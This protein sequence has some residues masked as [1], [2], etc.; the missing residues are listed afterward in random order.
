MVRILTNQGTMWVSVGPTYTYWSFFQNRAILLFIQD[1]PYFSKIIYNL[2]AIQSF[3][4]YKNF[5]C[6]KVLLSK[7]LSN[8]PPGQLGSSLSQCMHISVYCLSHCQD[9]GKKH[10]FCFEQ[11]K[12][13]K[14]TDK[15]NFISLSH[16]P[17]VSTKHSDFRYL[18]TY[19]QALIHIFQSEFL[20]PAITRTEVVK[21][22]WT[23][24]KLG[25]CQQFSQMQPISK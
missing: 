16:I 3:L 11:Q 19:Y 2:K 24:A 23:D 25:Q 10:Y 21:P 1:Q 8:P 9:N 17:L 6:K 14:I 7:L 13:F 18:H 20:L 12:L 15:W 5:N 22:K 4:A